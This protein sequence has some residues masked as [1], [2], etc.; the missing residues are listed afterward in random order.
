VPLLFRSWHRPHRLTAHLF[1]SRVPGARTTLYLHSLHSC[2][3]STD[4]PGRGCNV[5]PFDFT[6]LQ[7]QARVRSL[8][9]MSGS[10]WYTNCYLPWRLNKDVFFLNSLALFRVEMVTMHTEFATVLRYSLQ[11]RRE[12]WFRLTYEVREGPRPG[13][14]KWFLVGM[15][16]LGELGRV[17]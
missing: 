2:N 6:I 11:S 4:D 14:E 17:A 12:A 7:R 13:I 9:Q 15:E 1:S 3:P 8:G 16:E 10:S 5:L